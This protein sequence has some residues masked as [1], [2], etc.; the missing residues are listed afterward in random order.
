MEAARVLRLRGHNV[1]LLESTGSLG[2]LLPCASIV[3]G[4]HEKIYDYETYLKSQMEKLGVTVKL[5]ATAS[6][7]TIAE[8]K[9]DA[10]IVAT[11]G[12]RPALSFKGADKTVPLMDAIEGKVSGDSY[13]LVG[14]NVQA[15]D[16][17]TMLIKQG[18]RVTLVCSSASEQYDLDHPSWPRWQ[19]RRWCQSKGMNIHFESQISEVRDKECVITAKDGSQTVIP[20][21]VVVNSERMTPQK[22]LVDELKQAGFEAFVIGDAEA[23][24]TISHATYTAHMVA[25]TL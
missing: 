25:R 6:K 4:P 7:D 16:T 13:V 12:A 20:C 14:D 21:D 10:V 5:N 15:T 22:S 19:T 23:P 18:K 9:P 1:T 2:G 8:L 24:S 17:A 11:G 3:K